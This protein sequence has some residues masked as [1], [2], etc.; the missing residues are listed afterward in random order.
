M[1]KTLTSVAIAATM[2]TAPIAEAADKLL[3]KTPIA[4][5]T[6]LPGLGSPIPRV[7]EQLQLMSGGSLKMKVY[8]PGKLVPPFEIL[9]AV[10]SGKINSGY[11][12]A[13]YWAGKI[14][15]APLFSAVPFGPEAGEYMAWLY[16][17]NG[18][19]L[20]Q[21][22]Y[23]QAGFNV[24]VLPCAIIAPE[25]SGWFAKE[26]NQ[27]GDLDGLKM[28][29]FGLG[30]KVMQRLGVATSLLPGGE[31]FPALEKG[32]I[33]AT[34][35]SM[36][37][38]DA[39]LGFHK[40]V[41]YNYFPGWHQQATVFELLVNKDVWNEASDQHKAIIENACKASMTDSF[42]EGE[43]IQHAALIDNVENNGVEIKK[44]NDEMLATFRENWD[45]VAQEEAANDAF[46]AKVLG[47]MTEFRD[48]YAIWK[49]N[50]FLPR[51]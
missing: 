43:A 1:K 40:L 30:G 45:A 6:A 34:E 8:E 37:A 50:A 11:T 29:F 42:A 44:W 20:Y 36:P 26:I 12:T 18:M 10:S 4:F 16:Y 13:G 14:P 27:P 22:M 41:K 39:R 25:T 31:I 47:D 24:K 21:E 32:A 17:G 9:D 23:D 28:R 7:A 2:L 46:F 15:A 38:I 5:S 3:L 51:K 49:E 19:T 48:G 33:D 35:F